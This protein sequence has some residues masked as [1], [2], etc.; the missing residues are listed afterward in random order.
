MKTLVATLILLTL[1]GMAHA[2]HLQSIYVNPTLTVPA[3]STIEETYTVPVP[4]GVHGVAGWQLG[5]GRPGP[6]PMKIHVYL[7]VNGQIVG[8]MATEERIK[9]DPPAFTSDHWTATEVFVT[10]RCVNES[11]TE[12]ICRGAAAVHFNVEP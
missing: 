11:D 7:W 5:V 1:M 2:R 3:N 9:F 8:L 6:G 12:Q 4:P 10:V